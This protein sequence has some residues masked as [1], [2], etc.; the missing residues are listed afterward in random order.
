MEPIII[1]LLHG[2]IALFGFLILFLPIAWEWQNDKDGDDHSVK[3]LKWTIPSKTVDVWIRGGWMILFSF[4]DHAINDRSF[5]SSFAV[6]F[7]GHI[8]FFDY[9][10]AYILGHKDWFSYLGKKSF[11]DNLPFWS[12]TDPVTRF[13]IRLVLFTGALLH[14]FEISL[15]N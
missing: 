7:T 5:I 11:V 8:F 12:T 4:I 6:A 2:L 9:G 10:I 14:Y 1:N 3:I 13:L 15:I